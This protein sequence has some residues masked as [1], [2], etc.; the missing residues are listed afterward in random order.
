MN[1]LTTPA[2]NTPPAG[3]S[4]SQEFE[5]L[6]LRLLERVID[7]HAQISHVSNHVCRGHSSALFDSYNQLQAAAEDL[8]TLYGPIDAQSDDSLPIPPFIRYRT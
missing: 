7:L 8:A 5:V 6:R 4:A 3:P 2:A 1:Q